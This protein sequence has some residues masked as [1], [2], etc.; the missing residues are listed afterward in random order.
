MGRLDLAPISHDGWRHRC[1]WSA[2]AIVAY[3][4]VPIPV[5]FDGAGSSHRANR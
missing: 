2:L 4:L 3:T 5:S 1:G